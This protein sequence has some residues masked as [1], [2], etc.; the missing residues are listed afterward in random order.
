MLQKVLLTGS[1]CHAPEDVISNDEL[2]AS[3]N[4]YVE[5]FNKQHEQQI[6]AGEIEALRE[7]SDAFIVKASGIKNRHVIDKQGILSINLIPPP[8]EKP[9][10][11]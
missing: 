7:S 5:T 10:H 4:L 3:Y 6:A 8:P 1:A 9:T 2:V 11:T